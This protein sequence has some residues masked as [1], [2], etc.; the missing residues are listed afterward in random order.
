MDADNFLS[1]DREMKKVQPKIIF[2]P[3]GSSQYF[4]NTTQLLKG[5][6]LC[7]LMVVNY[8]LR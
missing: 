4:K 2:R 5:N 8:K 6:F 1:K 7:K 3:Q